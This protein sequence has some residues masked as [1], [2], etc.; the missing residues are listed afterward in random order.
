MVLLVMLGDVSDGMCVGGRC[1]AQRHCT[2]YS[3]AEE[4]QALQSRYTL[5]LT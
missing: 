3:A 5:M 1:R 4:A 2:N